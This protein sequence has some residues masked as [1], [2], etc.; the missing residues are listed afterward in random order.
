MRRVSRAVLLLA[1]SLAVVSGASATTIADEQIRVDLE[2][3]SVVAEV[4]VE[5]LTTDRFTFLTS[6]P[7]S[8][9]QGTV[10]GEPVP[11]SVESGAIES[12]VLCDVNRTEDFSVRLNYSASGLV[13]SEGGRNVFTYS[14]SFIRPTRNYSLTVVLPRGDALVDQDNI[15]TPV[16]SPPAGVTGS[17]GQRISVT[18]TAEPGLGESEVFQVIYESASEEP[19]SPGEF[20]LVA[21]IAVALLVAAAGFLVYRRWREPSLEEMLDDMEQDE[22][23]L[24][25]LLEDSGG[26]MLQKDVVAE[27]EYSKAKIS[28]VVS[29]LV[30]RGILKKEKEGRSNKLWISRR[31]RR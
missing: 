18:W 14:Q 15:S 21:A 28:G 16:V 25:E 17:N 22:R 27:M 24:L 29:E 10:D 3:S 5:E 9:V 1:A 31:Y 7:V 11:C 20:P 23:E 30:D 19:G 13:S 4:E 2:S 6:Y 26:E 12:Q 8:S